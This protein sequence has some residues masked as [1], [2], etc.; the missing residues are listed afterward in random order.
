MF[1][2]KSEIFLGFFVLSHEYFNTNISVM[3]TF[4]TCLTILAAAYFVYGRVLE[5]M[6][7]ID[8]RRSMPSSTHYD[9]VDYIP[10]PLWKTFMIQLLN[11]AGLGPFFGAVLGAAYGPV[12]FVWITVGAV[13]IGGV[14]DFVAGVI[15]VK[16]DGRSLPEIVGEYLGDGMRVFMRAFS[17]LLM[18]IVG[19]V[20]MSQP[21]KL[22]AARF[23]SS[24]LNVTA[25]GVVDEFSWLLLLF[26]G[27]ILVY[28]V[29][30]T[31]LPIDKLIGKL[32]PLFGIAM[33]FTAF[34]VLGALL[35]GGYRIPEL[36][37]LA[38]MKTGAADF[39]VIPMLCATISCGA[40]SGFHATQS[41]M[42]ARCLR[43]ERE[44]RPVFFGAMLLEGVIALVW[45]AMAMAF[46]GGVGGLNAH[47]AA[48]G[49]QAAVMIDEIS[50]SV[51]GPGVAV[52][53]VAGIVAS[54]I[55]SGDTAFRS[56]RLIVSDFMHIGQSSLRNR[57][58]VSLPLFAA[59]L[60]FVFLV[61]FQIAWN[62]MAWTNQVLAVVTLWTVT[63]YLARGG[64]A[65]VLTML[66]AMFMTFVC[67]SYVFVAPHMICLHDRAAAYGIGVAA[68]AAVSVC[69]VLR[70]ARDRRAC[71]GTKPANDNDKP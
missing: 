45:A 31:L 21:A 69:A 60:A 9:G 33:L 39:P 11:I 43:S 14:H 28:Y 19:A 7:G 56:A 35:W 48:T 18:V 4:L 24:P 2:Q 57:M 16:S 30:A 38:N 27:I 59:G 71:A 32:Y 65:F 68:T 25:F 44:C 6:C 66:P 40:I 51:F 20:F 49:G 64:R 29:V 67:T 1:G 22:L 12:A 42:M 47:I 54:A 5:R 34:G 3:T 62:T 53:V 36:T 63:A 23:A 13:L 58:A 15:S 50:T 46:W 37:S 26:I 61:P 17:V 52:L 55:T 10:M 70:M 8:P 41:P